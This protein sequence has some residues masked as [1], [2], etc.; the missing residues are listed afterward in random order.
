MNIIIFGSTG[1]IG[2]HL[3]KQ[4]L[5]AGHTVTAFTRSPNKLNLNHIQ[6]N[7]IQG[8]V[9]NQE[10]VE[11]AIKNQDAV[12]CV[13]GAGRKG[14]VRSRGTQHIIH[15]MKS[16]GVTRL[17][18]QSSLGVG[19]SRKNLNFFWK[20][21]MFGL[22]LRPAYHDHELQEAHVKASNLDWVIVRPGAFTDGERTGDYRHGFDPIDQSTVLKISRADVAD[23]LLKQLFDNRYLHQSPGL[24][25]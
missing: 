12:I 7:I 10:D 23:F 15:A 4:S 17:I 19:D 8:D 11:K 16:N 9:L 3:V 21:I 5:E 13:L 22:L 20:Y 2:Q 14:E 1:S 25:Y 6:L 24:S 18:C